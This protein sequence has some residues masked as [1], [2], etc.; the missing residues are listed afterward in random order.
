M[1]V[2]AYHLFRRNQSF[3]SEKILL[4]ERKVLKKSY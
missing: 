2:A 4:L 3:N 1:A